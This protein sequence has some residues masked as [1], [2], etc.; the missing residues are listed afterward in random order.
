MFS[1]D[2]AFASPPGSAREER[3]GRSPIVTVTD[4]DIGYAD[5]IVLRDLNFTVETG[6]ILFLLGASGSGKS[7]LLKHMIGLIP[8]LAGKILIGG[9]NLATAEGA[10][11]EA[12]LREIGVAYQ[13]GALLRSLTLKENVRLPLERFSDLP[14]EAMNEV[15]ALVLAQV[16]LASAVEALPERVSG[17]MQKRAAIAR[18]IVLSP[19]VVFLDEPSA[20]LDPITA[21][22]L[23]SLIRHLA[24]GLGLTFVIASHELS[25]LF[26]I[27][28]RAIM[29]RE[30][31]GL[32]ADGR[33]QA[34]RDGS[35]DPYVRRFLQSDARRRM[36]S[37]RSPEAE[38]S[39]G[40]N[41]GLKQCL[42]PCRTVQSDRQGSSGGSSR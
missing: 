13:Q 42:D 5:K 2:L 7:T 3:A 26:A 25:S 30:G 1:L 20:G 22:E 16:G 11:R 34:L 14:L 41:R 31:H 35:S 39:E 18:A 29:L 12:I 27:A 21:A 36:S 6:E 15:A 23:D 32:I 28:D 17:G 4:L 24:D 10:E 37:P 38:S 8:P 19:K 9:R 40:V 33:P